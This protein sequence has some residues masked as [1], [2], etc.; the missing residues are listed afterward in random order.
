[1]D[2]TQWCFPVYEHIGSQNFFCNGGSCSFISTKQ[3][4]RSSSPSLVLSSSGG[5]WF[6][7]CGGRDFWVSLLGSHW[8]ACSVC[9]CSCL[10]PVPSLLLTAAASRNHRRGKGEGI[11]KVDAFSALDLP[12]GRWVEWAGRWWWQKGGNCLSFLAPVV[13]KEK[14]AFS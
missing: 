13:R 8:S 9:S 5:T 6:S 4:N 7:G 1:M 10:F 14:C 2:L 3:V 11:G 12:L